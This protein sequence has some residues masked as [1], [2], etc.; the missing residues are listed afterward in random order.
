MDTSALENSTRTDNH[1]SPFGEAGL[2]GDP[3][4]Y[5]LGK[6]YKKFMRKTFEIPNQVLSPAI[7]KFDK[8][9]R[10]INPIHRAIDKTEIGGKIKD[11]VHE[12]PADSAGAI[13]GSVFGGGALLG[14]MGGG[15]AAGGGAA[16]GSAAAP[17]AGSFGGLGTG[18]AGGLQASSGLGVFADGGSAGM[19]GVGGGNAG[20]LAS[21]GGISGGA[22]I[23]SATEGGAAANWQDLA[24]E[25][26]SQQQQQQQ[27][28]TPYVGRAAELERQRQ[29]AEAAD[30]Q[31]K[32][33]LA[34][35]LRAQGMYTPA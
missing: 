31:K 7:K 16:G 25:G 29:A 22:G 30:L 32:Q 24:K 33:M 1:S 18:S 10:K 27:K 12:K 6:K 15:G 19:A 11:F 9:D 35:S 4:A 21:S 2:L 13:L 28:Q 23:G 3:L 34:A 8:F 17:A 14:G 20:A 26:M 5:L